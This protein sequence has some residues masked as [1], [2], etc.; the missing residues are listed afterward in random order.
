[1]REIILSVKD[2]SKADLLLSLLA[3]LDYV[4]TRPTEPSA[5]E[6]RLQWLSR[7][8]TAL[9]ASMNEDM[10]SIVRGAEIRPP[11]NFVD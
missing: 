8:H 4:E 9:D 10:P 6:S 5:A 3:D 2:S 1:M 7:L 11:V